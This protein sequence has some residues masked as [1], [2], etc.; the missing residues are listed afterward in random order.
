MLA[1]SRARIDKERAM[2][3]RKLKWLWGR[4][5]ELSAMR[6][7]RE[8]LLMKLGAARDKAR[9]AWRL[10]DIEVDPQIA[11]FSYALNRDKLRK[12]RRR[13]G[14]FLL[15]TNLY[16]HQPEKLWKF[17]IQLTEIEAAFKNLKGDLEVRPIFHQTIERIEAHIRRLPGLLSPRH[18]ACKAQ[19]VGGRPHAEGGARQV[20]RHPDARCSLP[21]YRRTDLDPQPLHRAE[22]RSKAS[23]QPAQPRNATS[24]TSQD[25][26]RRRNREGIN[27][28]FVVKT[29]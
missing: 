20:R 10:V 14:R 8:E 4:L 2:R 28:G 6:L 23:G 24:A 12:V 17:Y 13:E 25:Y 18:V 16:E 11:S 26:R 29:F 9:A 27:P 5:K 21:H 1:R 7:K 3:R 22:H 15:R 19:A